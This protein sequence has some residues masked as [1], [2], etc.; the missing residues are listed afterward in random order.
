MFSVAQTD[1]DVGGYSADDCDL[2]WISRGGQ[3]D[4]CGS[5][6]VLETFRGK[7]APTLVRLMLLRVLAFHLIHDSS[8]Q[9]YWLTILVPMI[10]V[11]NQIIYII[12]GKVHTLVQCASV[13]VNL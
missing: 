1:C 11:Q 10:L 13:E 6:V 5:R 4:L 8:Q 7:V 9:M 2:S 12:I 3:R